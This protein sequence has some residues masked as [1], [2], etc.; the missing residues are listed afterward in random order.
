MTDQIHAFFASLA[1]AWDGVCGLSWLLDEGASQVL[2]DQPATSSA[3]AEVVSEGLNNA[4]LHGQAQNV[5]IS[6]VLS[7]RYTVEVSMTDDGNGP[8]AEP[9]VGLG[10]QR[11]N[12]IAQ[13][14]SLERKN[15]RTLLSVAIANPP[16]H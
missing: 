8:L 15:G 4:V 1:N 2:S 6:I 7:S 9:G 12:T 16:W 3:V 11:L 10:S 13:S 5:D 14:W